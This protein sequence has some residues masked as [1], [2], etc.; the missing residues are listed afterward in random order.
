LGLGKAALPLKKSRLIEE[1][2][3]GLCPRT[4][5]RAKGK[6]VSLQTLRHPG[7]RRASAIDEGQG[8]AIL[9][10]EDQALIALEIEDSVRRNG[11]DLVGSAARLSEALTL[12]ETT[13]WDAALLDMKLANGEAVYP[14]AERLHAKGVPFAFLT[15]WDGDIDARYCDVPVLSKPFSLA[16]LESCLHTLVGGRFKPADREAA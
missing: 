6:S 9:I 10:V 5:H 14:V 3:P 11:A 15:A 1:P 7:R 8:F 12:I 16:E 4:V 13:S 2:D